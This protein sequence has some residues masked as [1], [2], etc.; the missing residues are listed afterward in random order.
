MKEPKEKK[1]T[2]K[3][4]NI[5]TNITK[6]KGEI[7]DAKR[8]KERMRERNIRTSTLKERNLRS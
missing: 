3:E 8:T 5:R 4:R 2:K 7:H 6:G 1:N